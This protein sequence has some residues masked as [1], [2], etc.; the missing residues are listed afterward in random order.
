MI[1]VCIKYG[2][3]SGK[4]LECLETLHTENIKREINRLQIQRKILL[5][6]KKSNVIRQTDQIKIILHTK[7]IKRKKKNIQIKW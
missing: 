7:K 4:H 1:R 2:F 3:I 5:F 6:V